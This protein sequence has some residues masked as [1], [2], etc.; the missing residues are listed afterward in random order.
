MRKHLWC[1]GG[2]AALATTLWCWPGD[3]ADAATSPAKARSVLDALDAAPATQPPASAGVTENFSRGLDGW[4]ATVGPEFP[5]AQVSLAVEP[6]QGPD[7]GPA[8]RLEGYFGKGGGYVGAIHNFPTPVPLKK[9]RFLIRPQGTAWVTIRLGD[10]NGSWHQI[11]VKFRGANL[12]WQEIALD[13]FTPGKIG[14]EC[15][16]GTW[17][18]TPE[19]HGWTGHVRS[20]QFLMDASSFK[21][22]GTAHGA[23][24][25]CDVRLLP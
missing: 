23:F 7:G 21:V 22:P 4:R 24:S 16:Y 9:L 2:A 13:G 1:I 17:G 18:G 3:A 25:I 15:E 12:D 20:L 8:M 10:A 14:E 11:R 6:G 19:N 5:G